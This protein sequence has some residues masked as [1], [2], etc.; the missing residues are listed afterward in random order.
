MATLVDRPGCR[1]CES[2]EGGP[3][4]TWETVTHYFQQRDRNTSGFRTHLG[5]AV[6]RVVEITNLGIFIT[7][8]PKP[9]DVGSG[10]PTTS[11]LWGRTGWA[12]HARGAHSGLGTCDDTFAHRVALP[13]LEGRLVEG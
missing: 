12:V 1:V 10:P 9:G 13:T 11:P 8:S 3:I 5:P 6:S 7:C 2:L 4:F